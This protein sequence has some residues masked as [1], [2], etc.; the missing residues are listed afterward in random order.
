[1]ECGSIRVLKL[2][3]GQFE[4][5]KFKDKNGSATGAKL[6]NPDSFDS[7]QDKFVGMAVFHFVFVEHN[8]L[9]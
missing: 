2:T 7:A 8:G 5:V 4:Y 3:D 9:C 6:W 1:M